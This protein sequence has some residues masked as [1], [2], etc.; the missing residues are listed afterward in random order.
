ME[1]TW[2]G[3]AGDRSDWTGRVRPAS[4]VD[5]TGRHSKGVE[6]SAKDATR[7]NWSGRQ[8]IRMARSRRRHERQAGD[9][10]GAVRSRVDWIGRSTI[11]SRRKG[12]H[13]NGV[14]LAGN[15]REWTARRGERRRAEWQAVDGCGRERCRAEWQAIERNGPEAKGPEW[16]REAVMVRMG[17]ATSRPERKGSRRRDRSGERDARSG[18]DL[19]GRAVKEGTGADTIGEER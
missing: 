7:S 11:G 18:A 1:G 4:R 17:D 2:T 6:T 5:W 19:T 3:E 16:I 8:A 12:S 10:K 9:W 15:R 14:G 13:T